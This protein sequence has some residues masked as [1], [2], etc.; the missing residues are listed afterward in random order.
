MENMAQTLALLKAMQEMTARLEA[1][2]VT[3]LREVIEDMKAA[4]EE[5]KAEMKAYEKR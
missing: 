5:R 2:M 1:K 3:N 4:R